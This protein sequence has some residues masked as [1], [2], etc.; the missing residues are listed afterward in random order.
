MAERCEC[1]ASEP[2]VIGVVGYDVR[3]AA[4]VC[5]AVTRTG[6]PPR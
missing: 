3:L 5:V 4:S 1:H 2:L 6:E